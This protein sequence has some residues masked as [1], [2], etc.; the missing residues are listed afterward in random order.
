MQPPI[1]QPLQRLF[2]KKQENGID[3]LQISSKFRSVTSSPNDSW[4]RDLGA[5]LMAYRIADSP[6]NMESK[7]GAA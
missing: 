1:Y 3:A 4:S 2:G 5:R 6:D 7:F